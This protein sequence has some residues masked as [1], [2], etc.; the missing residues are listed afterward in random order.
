MRSRKKNCSHMVII[1]SQNKITDFLMILA[2]ASPYKLKKWTKDVYNYTSV[3]HGPSR[4]K[5]NYMATFIRRLYFLLLA[6]STQAI[7]SDIH[8][9]IHIIQI[10]ISVNTLFSGLSWYSLR[11]DLLTISTCPFKPSRC[12]KALFYISEYL[13][14]FPKSRGFKKKIFMELFNN[15]NTCIFF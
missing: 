8:S 11:R 10:Y 9:D 13:L 7:H 15:N 2:W 14:N 6:F 12:I 4:T 3:S 1:R 5:G